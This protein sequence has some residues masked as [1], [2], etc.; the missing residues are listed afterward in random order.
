MLPRASRPTMLPIWLTKRPSMLCWIQ[1]A[2][3]SIER[4]IL[5]DERTPRPDAGVSFGLSRR[6]ARRIRRARV[7]VEDRVGHASRVANGG[8]VSRLA[9]AGAAGRRPLDTAFP[10]PCRTRVGR[11]VLRRRNRSLLGQPLRAR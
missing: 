1:L 8:A 6:R 3:T 5:N 2:Q 7:E 9:C 10:G 11:M 4:Q